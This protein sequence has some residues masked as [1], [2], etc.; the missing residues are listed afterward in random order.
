MQFIDD[1]S[2]EKEALYKDSSSNGNGYGVFL[3]NDDELD[4][5]IMHFEE[6]NQLTL[7]IYHSKDI[8]GN[9]IPSEAIK[10]VHFE[11]DENYDVAKLELDEKQNPYIRAERNTEK[12]IFHLFKISIDESGITLTDEAMGIS[13]TEAFSAQVIVPN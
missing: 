6:K 13:Y 8:V 5:L 7:T 10:T 4:N 11:L 9:R 2:I 1:N 3:D 12:P